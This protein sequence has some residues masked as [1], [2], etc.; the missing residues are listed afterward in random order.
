MD[1]N[2]RADRKPF[3]RE[4]AALDV[5]LRMRR[6]RYDAISRS[7]GKSSRSFRRKKSEY[8]RQTIEYAP[9]ASERNVNVGS[10]LDEG[11]EGNALSKAD[12]CN[13][14]PRSIFGIPIGEQIDTGL[15]SASKNVS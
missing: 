15:R 10:Q 11:N 9:S 12:S 1:A 6:K 13:L 14:W 8:L 4:C 5:R 3:A 7:R 2:P